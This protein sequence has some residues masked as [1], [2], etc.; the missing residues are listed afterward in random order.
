[1]EKSHLSIIT[2]VFLMIFDICSANE[3]GE[4]PL[5]LMDAIEVALRN[6]RDLIYRANYDINIATETYKSQPMEFKPR[7]NFSIRESHYEKESVSSRDTSKTKTES[8]STK[9]LS[10]INFEWK[11][12]FLLGSQIN[13]AG[14]ID[15]T[16]ER[17]KT[18]EK[19]EETK[20][21]FKKEYVSTPSVGLEWMQPL[22]YS[23]IKAGHASL[24]KVDLNYKLAKLNYQEAREDLIFQVINSYYGLWKAIKSRELAERQLDLTR[25]LLNISETKLQTGDIAELEIMRLKVRLSQDEA[26]LIETKRTERENLRH[27]STLLG[28]EEIRKF[29]LSEKELDFSNSLFFLFLENLSEELAYKEALDNR[30]DIKKAKINLRLQDLNLYKTKSEDDPF[31][32]VNGR[33]Q[34]KNK[35]K[36]F[37]DV[38][39]KFPDKEWEIFGKISLPIFDGGVTKAN[40]KKASL[41][42]KKERYNYE[43]LKRRIKR[44]IEDIFESLN[45]HKRRLETLEMSLDIAERTLKISQLKYEE[46]MIDSYEVLEAQISLFEVRNS[47]T[48]AKIS[49]IIDMARLV[50]A[51]G[52]LGIEYEKKK[53]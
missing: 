25:C 10:T 21:S 47:I 45:S 49:Q 5:S 9:Y 13:L 46:G 35:D 24:I 16:K 28:F 51:M 19:A 7:S 39:E 43:E 27:F 41:E 34:W 20:K 53:D 3:V 4:K 36:E 37:E 32:T 42:L 17:L 2:S 44:E 23:G 33:Y 26:R 8:L 1:M 40:I 30:I 14:G 52:R 50:K 31:L 15:L 48:E 22:T 29:I 18:K 38:L 12:P 6:N 11:I